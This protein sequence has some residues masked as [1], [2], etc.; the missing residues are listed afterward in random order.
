LLVNK[1]EQAVTEKMIRERAYELW[2]GNGSPEG[3]SEVNW[4]TAEQE[5]L[6]ANGEAVTSSCLRASGP[7][8]HASARQNS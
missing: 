2:V 6:A 5:I 8:G 7:E 3:Q 1:M 4:I